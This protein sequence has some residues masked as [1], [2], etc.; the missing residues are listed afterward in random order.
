M[1][2][3]GARTVLIVDNDSGMRCLLE[4]AV[5]RMGYRSVAAEG[6]TRAID[7][8]EQGVDAVLLDLPGLCSECHTGRRADREVW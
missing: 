6:V 8:I 3:G 4:S 7:M 2:E 1:P 5:S